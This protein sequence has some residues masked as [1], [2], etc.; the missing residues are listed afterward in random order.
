MTWTFFLVLFVRSPISRHNHSFPNHPG[1]HLIPVLIHVGCLRKMVPVVSVVGSHCLALG[2][3]KL[4][5]SG[6]VPL[7]LSSTPGVSWVAPIV[8]FSSKV[9]SVAGRQEF[10]SLRGFCSVLSH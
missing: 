10:Y 2:G 6:A 9:L 4:V 8:L 7:Q 5:G 1:T 3:I